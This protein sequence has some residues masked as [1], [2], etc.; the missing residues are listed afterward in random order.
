MPRREYRDVTGKLKGYSQKS[1]DRFR[2]FPKWAA[3]LMLVYFL[4]EIIRHGL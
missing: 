1:S 2:W 3:Y 4:Y